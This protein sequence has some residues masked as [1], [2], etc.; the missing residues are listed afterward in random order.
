MFSLHAYLTQT[1]TDIRQISLFINP[2]RFSLNIVFG[3]FILLWFVVKDKNLKHW[4]RFIMLSVMTWFIGFLVILESMIGMLSLYVIALGLIFVKFLHLKKKVYVLSLYC[5]CFPAPLGF[6]YIKS[7][8]D[9]L[10]RAPDINFEALPTHTAKGNPYV[11]DTI[12]YGIE[13]GTYI[14]LY[15]SV[16]ELQEAWNKRGTIDLTIWTGPINS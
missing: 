14:G 1:F 11:H 15:L 2:I 5:C 3:F 10:N 7:I 13:D 16:D 9:E 4:Q 6:I 8:V 12:N